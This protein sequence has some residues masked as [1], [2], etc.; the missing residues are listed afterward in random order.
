MFYVSNWCNKVM[1][2]GKQF[3]TLEEGVKAATSTIKR[4]L[5]NARSHGNAV[6]V[7]VMEAIPGN[8]VTRAIVNLDL[9]VTYR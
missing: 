5:S 3:T 8:H 6:S 2:G 9:T 7:D 1:A 4:S